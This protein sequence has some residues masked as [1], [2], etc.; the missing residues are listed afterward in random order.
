MVRATG[1]LDLK[2]VGTKFFFCNLV[3]PFTSVGLGY[4]R[5]GFPFGGSVKEDY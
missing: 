1:Y 3:T 5:V 2:I 4:F